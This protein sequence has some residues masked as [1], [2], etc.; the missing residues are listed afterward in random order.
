MTTEYPIKTYPK[1]DKELNKLTKT[2][3]KKDHLI[4]N[5]SVKIKD[6]ICLLSVGF[7]TEPLSILNNH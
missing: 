2:K 3:M 7:L 6:D 5:F 1:F 4:V